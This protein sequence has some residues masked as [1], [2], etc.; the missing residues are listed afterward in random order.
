MRAAR[1]GQKGLDSARSRPWSRRSSRACGLA[2]SERG[3]G[4]VAFSPQAIATTGVTHEH[5]NSVSQKAAS[6]SRMSSLKATTP[7]GEIFSRK[8]RSSVGQIRRESSSD[9]LSAPSTESRSK[10]PSPRASARS[11]VALSLAGRK[12][13]RHP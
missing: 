11:V 13:S 9:R 12:R 3:K 2:S 7:S 1:R 6:S 4:I 8:A 5:W 10:R